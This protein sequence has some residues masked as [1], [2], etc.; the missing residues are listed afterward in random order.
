M[1]IK[2]W[3]VGERD[4]GIPDVKRISE[5]LN[6]TY[7]TALLLFKRGLRTAEQA[8]AFISHSAE[9]FCDPFLL[10]DAGK[11][12]DRILS[13]VENGEKITVY[14]DYDVDGITSTCTM[15][16]YLK[17]L[18]ADVTY[19]IPN[20]LSDGYGVNSDA[21]KKITDRGSTLIITVDTGTTAIDE[22][23][24]AG[25]RGCDFVVTDH[26]EC[27]ETLPAAVAVVNPKRPDSSYPFPELAGVG[28]AFKL[29]CALETVYRKKNGISPAGMLEQLCGDYLDLVSIGTVADVM[30]LI[31]EN[32]LIVSFG[33]HNMN[34]GSRRLGIRALVN[35]IDP[36]KGP[37]KIITA[38]F[39][40]YQLA[41]R[42]NSA[43]RMGNAERAV[44]LFLAS[45]DVQ[46]ETA[47]AE[48]CDTNSFRKDEE[49][50]I[51][52]S[53]N[54][55]IAENPALAE[56][57]VIVLSSEG[58]HHGVI[59]I[60][61]TYVEEKY[62][63]PAIMVSFEDGVGKGSGRSVKGFN[64]VAALTYSSEYLIKY[65]GHELAAG[66]T[67]SADNYEAFVDK[68]NEYAELNTESCA[69]PVSYADFRLYPAEITLRQAEEL[70][71]L[72]PCG[73]KNPVPVFVMNGLT[74]DE[75]R[76]IGAG[77][78]HTRFSF[79]SEG[80]TI[81][82]VLFRTRA[83]EICFS[84]GEKA[85]VM[86]YLSVNDFGNSRSAQLLVNEIRPSAAL[87]EK[88]GAACGR[89]K[90]ILNGD[91][92]AEPAEIPGRDFFASVYRSAKA[93]AWES[94]T[95]V[96]HRLAECSD[97]DGYVKTRI[98]LE[99]LN[100]AGALK[101]TENPDSIGGFEIFGFSVPVLAEKVNLEETWL[102]RQL[103]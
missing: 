72:E 54:K 28:V 24:E 90:S 36:Q 68:I 30:P 40:G 1:I 9:S 39:I 26:H 86:F 50:K 92:K 55:M 97:P 81:S 51:R 80:K 37:S 43:G 22:I 10:P 99:I 20:R 8:M 46:A 13:A 53:V 103:I 74:V 85:D 59:G 16:L 5:K 88:F 25:A 19:Y 32:R 91:E 14:G 83:D 17:T 70:T 41:P 87:L 47:A 7:P 44:E 60:I 76:P 49:Q 102:Y 57:R 73:E 93:A 35:R 58:W 18:G 45:D 21:V 15:F 29:V 95:L 66:L 63:K 31:G 6:I 12:C 69:R 79:S 82:G 62:G 48:L 65:G 71:L 75:I 3:V 64:L 27:R 84:R 96:L 101:L 67:V 2:K 89:Y 23:A 61:A 33:L 56:R 34:R 11:A 98:A 100:E 78:V 94:S 4:D 77:A 38:S 52:Q 42:L